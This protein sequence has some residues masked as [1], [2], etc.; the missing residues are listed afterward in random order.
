MALYLGKDKVCPITLQKSA[1]QPDGG[2][3]CVRGTAIV[4]EDGVITFP[5]LEFTPTIFAVWNITRSQWNDESADWPCFNGAMLFA[6]YTDLGWVAQATKAGS[7]D[8]YIANATYEIGPDTI[9]CSNNVYK[10]KVDYSHNMGMV[11]TE[12]NYVIY[13]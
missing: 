13:G 7:G 6:V 11:N 3:K 1:S 9:T 4:D 10:Y 5:E 2:I 12:L 8:A